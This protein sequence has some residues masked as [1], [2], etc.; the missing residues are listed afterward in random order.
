MQHGA[1]QDKV[2]RGYGTA[3]RAIGE[4]CDVYRPT[5]GAQA[6]AGRNHLM[7]LSATFLPLDGRMRAPVRHG[8]VTWQGVFD[9][10]YTRPG[11]FL[12]R[13]ASYP[14]APDAAVFFIAAQQKLLPP[15]C[16]RTSAIIQIARAVVSNTV[17]AADYGGA[18]ALTSVTILAN[19]PASIVNATGTGLNPL[20]LPATVAPGNWELLFP[21]VPGLV[22]R[23]ND[24]VSDDLGRTAIVTATEL[25]DLGWRVIAKEI[26]S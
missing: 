9:A 6:L 24:R 21:T 3:A 2:S 15:L 12:V 7:R 18:G 10:A 5:R 26:A 22:L 25:S 19:W 20:E 8:H 17:G 14:G 23:S 1:I 11:D 13:S 4:W 16:V